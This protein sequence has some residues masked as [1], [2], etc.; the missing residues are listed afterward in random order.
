MR[1]HDID[2]DVLYSHTLPHVRARTHT[3]MHARINPYFCI[4]VFLAGWR[5]W[6]RSNRSPHRCMAR[7]LHMGTDMRVGM[8]IVQ[9]RVLYRHVYEHV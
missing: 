7:V 1:R 2:K 9:A 5:V 4:F 8:C 3:H 6:T